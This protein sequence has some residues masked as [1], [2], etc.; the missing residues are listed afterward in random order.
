M[1]ASHEDEM[2]QV[3]VSTS[4]HS[5]NQSQSCIGWRNVWTHIVQTTCHISS[6]GRMPYIDTGQNYHH[7]IINHCA[8][9]DEMTGWK[10][11]ID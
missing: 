10:P 6:L 3:K 1:K 9:S 8:E 2:R 5:S 7:S 4:V 11:A